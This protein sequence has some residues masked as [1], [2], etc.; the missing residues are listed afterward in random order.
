MNTFPLIRTKWSNEHIMA[1]VFLAVTAY[2]IPIWRIN[3]VELA[4]FLLLVSTGL[5]IDVICNFLRY[6]RI[7]CSVSAAVTAGLLSVLTFGVPLWGRLLGLFIALIPGKHIW[8]GT[9][10][11]PLNPAMVGLLP[12]LFMF[13]ISFPLL[14]NSWLLLL[15]A[16]LSLPFLLIRPYAGIGYLVGLGAVMLQYGYTPKE[17]LINGGLLLACLVVT[18]PVTVTREPFI[19]LTGGF[20]A[21]FV[22][23]YFMGSPLYAV[24]G[25]LTLNLLSYALERGS[26][27]VESKQLKVTRLKLPKLYGTAGLPS[28]LLD[29][30]GEKTSNQDIPQGE[31]S[32]EEILNR[33]KKAGV[34]GMGGAGFDTYR[35]LIA[36]INSQAEE[37]YFILNG[38]ECDPG[39]IH[40]RWLLKAVPEAIFSGVKLISSCADFK[41]VTLAV[42]ETEDLRL[43]GELKLC[44]VP[45]QYPAGAEKL[46][47]SEVLHKKLSREQL[48]AD[49]GILVLNV[50]TVYSVYEAVLGNRKA[51]T[52]FITV[53]DLRVPV[54]KVA[55]VRLGMKVH[56]ILEETYP[57]ATTAYVGGGLM[58]AYMAEEETVVDQ[59]VNFIAAAQFPRY[60]ESP[61]CSG[62]GVCVANCPASLSVNHVADLVDAGKL[63]EATGYHPEA[64]ISCGSCSYSCLAGR[65]LSL[66]VKKAKAAVMDMK[67]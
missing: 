28:E 34:F 59:H 5:L 53:A 13:H 52:R 22:G 24:L 39:L 26:G 12:L 43:P 66:R 31:L 14:P 27:K 36:V 57:G 20:L 58:Q 55:K 4:I 29:L 10:K 47:I 25:I 65:N 3:P 50:Q 1:A 54:A 62:C 33:I 63:K 32:P 60:K 8:G 19:G 23:L 35:K 7:W 16:I 46:L 6:K 56:K 30:T 44:Q 15:G 48:P 9:G 38:V 61:Q 67:K 2:H 51:D 17:L 18:D 21:G 49:C 45:T 41:S 42:K 64:C 40:D 37:K 11:N